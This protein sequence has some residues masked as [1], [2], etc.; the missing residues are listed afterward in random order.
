[1]Y[2]KSEVHLSMLRLDTTISGRAGVS[3]NNDNIMGGDIMFLG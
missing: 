3:I 2:I 1:V